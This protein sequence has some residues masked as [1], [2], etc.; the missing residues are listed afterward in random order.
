MEREQI[1]LKVLQCI[2]EVNPQSLRN[3][4]LDYPIDPFL[5]EAGRELLRI[6]PLSVFS[7]YF[8]FSD[9]EVHPAED[10]SGWVSL[11]REFISLI[12]FQMEGWQ[13]PVTQTVN[14]R[15]W[16]YS[17]QFHKVLRGGV[18]RPVVVID[19]GRLY[20]Y[21]LPQGTDHAIRRADA[22]V[23]IPVGEDYPENL[24]DA[25]AWLAASKVLTVMN[26]PGAASAAKEQFLDLLAFSGSGAGSFFR[27][28]RV[29]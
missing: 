21:S 18:S 11:P 26:E 10:G 9:A 23:N 27:K 2:D 28:E 15:S 17:R 20:Y 22:L 14:N 4:G 7:E 6:V 8:D 24:L 5:D 13:R 25:L 12:A 19:G 3:Q 16:N 1:R 29:S